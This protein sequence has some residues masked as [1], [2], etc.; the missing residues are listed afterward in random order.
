MIF[1]PSQLS[2][3]IQFI[4]E[5]LKI[6]P[7]EIKPYKQKKTLSQNN[8][9]WLLF[10]HVGFETGNTK[11]TIYHYCIEKFAPINTCYIDK[12]EYSDKLTLSQFTKEQAIIFINNILAEFQ[13][14]DLPDPEDIKCLQMY[15]FYKEKGLL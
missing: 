5:H 3:A 12:I 14:Y 1:K 8:Y 2:Q 11:E 9:I 6:N 15:E 10:T 13:E 4:T 7:V